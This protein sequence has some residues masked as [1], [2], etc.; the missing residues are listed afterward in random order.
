[1]PKGTRSGSPGGAMPAGAVGTVAAPSSGSAGW[2]APRSTKN[3]SPAPSTTK[4]TTSIQRR[5][6]SSSVTPAIVALPRQPAGRALCGGAVEAER[7]GH[8]GAEVVALGRGGEGPR[9]H[10][11]GVRG[12]RLDRRPAEVR[13]PA[14]ELRQHAV[15]DAEDVVEHEHLAVAAGPGAD[16]HR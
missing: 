9:A 11:G 4:A 1:S 15:L 8:L 3:Q 2:S 5:A 6:R 14:H 13:V 7:L 12:Q 16:A 10:V